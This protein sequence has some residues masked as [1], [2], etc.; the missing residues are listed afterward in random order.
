MPSLGSP[1]LAIQTRALRKTYVSATLK[2]TVA[3]S[4]LDLEVPL[5]GVHGFLGPNG[6]GKTTTIRMLLGMIRADSGT[7][8]ILGRPVP[9]RLPDVI[10]EIGAIVEQPK[11]Y[12][13]FSGRNNLRLLATAIGVEAKK[14][15][16]VLESVGLSERSK[17]KY[18]TYSLGMKQRLA[19]AATLLKD[20][21]LLIFDEPTNGLDPAGIQ[22]I[23]ETMRDL[24]A[25]G[26]TVMVSSHI[27][28]E[29][30]QVA[31]TVSIIGRGN[32]LASGS[33]K[34]LI[35]G[36]GSSQVLVR[37]NDLAAASEALREFEIRSRVVGDHLIVSGVTDPAQIT[38]LLANRQLFVSELTPQNAGLEKLFL[39]LTAGESPGGQ[40]VR[41]RAAGQ[42]AG[43]ASAPSIE[44]TPAAPTT[45][46]GL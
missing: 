27:L 22:E 5:G 25:R 30:E 13:Q 19:I 6:S 32:V 37:V 9:G 42:H 34:E 24:G 10:S 4:G 36:A 23:R 8:E 45:E 16:E 20:P 35:A 3:V 38:Y 1:D 12:P 31:D 11:F 17:G 2:R 44:T 33:V 21:S 7:M 41:T 40:S 29:V 15:D 18:R 28:S 43:H 39:D 14:I 46:G 26:K